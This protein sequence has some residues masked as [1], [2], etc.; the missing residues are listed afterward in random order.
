MSLLKFSN[1][2]SRLKAQYELLFPN[3]TQIQ[4]RKQFNESA[5]VLSA[6]ARFTNWNSIGSL[7]VSVFGDCFEICFPLAYYWIIHRCIC[8]TVIYWYQNVQKRLFPQTHHQYDA[9][10]ISHLPDTNRFRLFIGGS[11]R[12]SIHQIT[13]HH[14]TRVV[15][16]PVVQIHVLVV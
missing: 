11:F 6:L 14:T 8:L 7:G 2:K 5:L 9:A 3:L 1:R 4:P 15:C 16:L 13:A 12:E 10:I